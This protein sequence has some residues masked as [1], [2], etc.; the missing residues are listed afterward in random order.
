[1]ESHGYDIIKN[2]SIK[3]KNQASKI[4][5]DFPSFIEK[6]KIIKN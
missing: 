6:L 3:R 2:L 1:M 4:G 5:K